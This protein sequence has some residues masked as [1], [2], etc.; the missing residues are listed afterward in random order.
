MVKQVYSSEAIEEYIV[1]IVKETRSKES[2]YS[3]YISYG[4]SPRASIAIHIAAKAEALMNG[5]DYVAPED[6][7]EV[8]Y[9]VLRHRIILN[10][11]AD[12]EN[13]TTDQIIEQILAK[14]GA[15]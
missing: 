7:R 2:E 1:K 15:P 10:Y 12:A 3:K 11:E 9:P 13:I 4:G 8:V 14:I 6:V 5:R